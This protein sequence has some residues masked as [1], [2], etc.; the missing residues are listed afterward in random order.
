MSG[1]HQHLYNAQL[2]ARQSSTYLSN[3]ACGV[4]MFMIL[5]TAACGY[6]SSKVHLQHSW[7]L[8]EAR[9]EI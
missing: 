3:R 5:F 2:I 4:G 1:Q 6:P 7:Y 9:K 8:E